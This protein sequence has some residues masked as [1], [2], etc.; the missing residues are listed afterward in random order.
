MSTKKL[1]QLAFLLIFALLVLL[2][3]SISNSAIDHGLRLCKTSVLPVLFPFFVLTNLWSEFGLTVELSK[4]TE[5]IINRTFH[6]PGYCSSAMVLGYLGG[7]PIGAQIVSSLF[8]KEMI[9]KKQAEHCLMFCNNAGPGFILGIIGNGLFQSIQYG[10]IMLLIHWTSS[11]IIGLLFRAKSAATAAPTAAV[12]SPTQSIYSSVTKSIQNAGTTTVSVCTFILFF[13]LFTGFLM[14]ILSAVKH[15]PFVSLVL[16]FI[17]LTNG[18]EILKT[19]QSHSIWIFISAAILTGWGGICVHCQTLSILSD[20]PLSSKQYWIGKCLHAIFSGILAVLVVPFLFPQES[21][22]FNRIY[23]ICII[24][25][26][27]AFMLFVISKKF[28]WKKGHPSYII[29]P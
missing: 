13:S 6:L 7:Y 29:S 5:R 8:K 14:H 12:Q 24:V 10:F 27:L 17:E 11:I 26:I 20:L 2:F 22:L 23:R 3:P 4:K 1:A 16:G 25:L 21:S 19:K 18:I 15:S 28:L 9:T